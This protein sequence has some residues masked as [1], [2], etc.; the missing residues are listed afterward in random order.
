MLYILNDLLKNDPEIVCIRKLNHRLGNT[1]NFNNEA[2]L[3]LDRLSKRNFIIKVFENNLIDEDFMSRHWKPYE[4][5]RISIY[6]DE[7][8]SLFYHFFLPVKNFSEDTASHLIHD[9]NNYILSSYIFYGGGYK[10]IEFD[11]INYLEHQNNNLAVNKYLN[12]SY[13]NTYTLDSYTPHVIFNV[14]GF[15]ASV[16]LWSNEKESTSSKSRINYFV[17]ENKIIGYSDSEF[18]SKIEMIDKD[19]DIH[20]QSFCYFL[21]KFNY[22]NDLLLKNIIESKSL[23]SKWKKWLDFLLNRN[24]IKEPIFQSNI[25]TFNSVIKKDMIIKMCRKNY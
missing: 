23:D 8:F 1:L 19:S 20:I 12:H 7:N 10:T 22:K 9:H 21:Q 13:K 17:K 4:L 16:V 14:K 11:R 25:N 24:T 5:P 18:I 3:L 15:T 6:E 2:S